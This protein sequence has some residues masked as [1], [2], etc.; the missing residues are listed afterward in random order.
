MSRGQGIVGVAGDIRVSTL[1]REPGPA[2]YIA[3]TQEP[4][5]F[6]SLVIRTSGS[7]ALAIDAVRK[8]IARADPEQGVSLPYLEDQL[9]VRVVEGGGVHLIPFVTLHPVET[10]TAFDSGASPSIFAASRCKS[11]GSWVG[12]QSSQPSDEIEAT[13]FIV[14]SGACA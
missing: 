14:S 8:A 10:V 1:D 9:G 13:Q 4:S 12:V 3:H 6:A 2:I 5:L 11:F 7:P